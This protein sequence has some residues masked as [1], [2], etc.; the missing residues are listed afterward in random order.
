MK[1]LERIWDLKIISFLKSQ[2]IN[3]IVVLTTLPTAKT[4]RN[5][6]QSKIG[7]AMLKYNTALKQRTDIQVIDSYS[8]FYDSAKGIGKAEYYYDGIHLNA[9]GK[10]VL[11]DFLN[12]EI[13]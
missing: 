11:K 12:R 13:K 6:A 10:E 9:K 2:G 4:E 7:D 8:L 1:D 5:Y 3:N